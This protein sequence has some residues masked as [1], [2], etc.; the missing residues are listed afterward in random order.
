MKERGRGAGLVFVQW[1]NGPGQW[2]QGGCTATMRFGTGMLAWRGALGQR[3]SSSLVG[4]SEAR[5]RIGWWLAGSIEW[6]RRWMVRWWLDW[7]G[8]D[9]EEGGA[10]SVR[11]GWPGGEIEERQVGW[12][13]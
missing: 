4:L 6:R 2:I 9:P 13:R 5:R 10:L 7:I 1:G 3:R 8:Q 12:W 11:T